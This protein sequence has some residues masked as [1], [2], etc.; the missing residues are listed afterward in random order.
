MFLKL[1]GEERFRTCGEVSL[2]RGQIVT[3]ANRPFSMTWLKA[4]PFI[5]VHFFRLDE[6]PV[7]LKLINVVVVWRNFTRHSPRIY[8]KFVAVQDWYFSSRRRIR[9]IVIFIIFVELRQIKSTNF[10]HSLRWREFAPFIRIHPLA[11]RLRHVLWHD[12]EIWRIPIATRIL[13]LGEVVAAEFERH[14]LGIFQQE[15]LHE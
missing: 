9:I 8:I 7:V 10:A 1:A 4:F 12:Q 11:I 15:I 5:I 14:V 13:A 3:D 2:I 6:V